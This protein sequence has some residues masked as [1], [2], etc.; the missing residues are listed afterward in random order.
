V[1]LFAIERYVRPAYLRVPVLPSLRL[2]ASVSIF[3]LVCDDRLVSLPRRGSKFPW[4]WKYT[5]RAPAWT[6]GWSNG[7]PQPAGMAM[8]APRRLV[9]A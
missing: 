8:I 3:F 2:L 5:T 6:T 4:T 9:I 7:Q 1:Y